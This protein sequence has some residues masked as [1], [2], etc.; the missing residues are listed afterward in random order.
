MLSL[1]WTLHNM[2]HPPPQPTRSSSAGAASVSPGIPPLT[3]GSAGLGVGEQEGAAGAVLR[4]LQVHVPKGQEEGSARGGAQPPAA[5]GVVGVGAWVVL[6]AE[7]AAVGCQQ[8]VATA[9]PCGET[10]EGGCSAGLLP[11]PASPLG[12]VP[13]TPHGHHQPLQNV[14][15][16]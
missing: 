11:A 1:S 4:G 13:G 16:A 15:L 9:I 12:M 10:G 8:C 6:G 7:G 14:F 3:V 2:N 5:G